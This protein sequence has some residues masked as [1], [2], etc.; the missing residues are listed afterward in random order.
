MLRQHDE[1]G[2]SSFGWFTLV[3]W[4]TVLILVVVKGGSWLWVFSALAWI[5]YSIRQIRRARREE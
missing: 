3:L 5:G 2:S 1:V 4:T